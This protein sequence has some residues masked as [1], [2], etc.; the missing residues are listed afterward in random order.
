MR[1]ISV[2]SKCVFTFEFIHTDFDVQQE[3]ENRTDDCEP[4]TSHQTTSESESSFVFEI[5]HDIR[6]QLQRSAA[7]EQDK[8][9]I[10]DDENIDNDSK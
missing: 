7:E 5:D 3:C 9:E 2:Y 8:M 6:L 1:N 10:S 4:S